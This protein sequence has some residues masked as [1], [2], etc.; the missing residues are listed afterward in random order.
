MREREK[1][2]GN[3]LSSRLAL[4]NV[5]TDWDD[6]RVILMNHCSCVIPD[7]A[8]PLYPVTNKLLTQLTACCSFSSC[9]S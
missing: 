5:Q 9:V 7:L 2:D 4:H 1:G 8:G 3:I 6:S